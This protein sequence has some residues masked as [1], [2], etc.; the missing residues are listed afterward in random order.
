MIKRLIIVFLLA[1]FVTG[2]AMA[3]KKKDVNKFKYNSEAAVSDNGPAKTPVPIKYSPGI[4]NTATCNGISTVIPIV[5]HTQIGDTWY[6]YQQNGSMGRM[7]SVSSDG[8]RH[9]VWHY[10]SGVYGGTVY[11]YVKSNEAPAGAAPLSWIGAQ[12]VDGGAGI[13]AG[14][15]NQTHLSDGTS[16]SIYHRTAGSP[17]WYSAIAAEDSAC[18]NIW[19]RHWDIPDYIEGATSG[20]PGEWPKGEV[21]YDPTIGRDYIHIVAQEG[22]T[23][24]DVAMMIYERC[25][26]ADGPGFLDTMICQTYRGGATQTCKVVAGANGPGTFFTVSPFDS[27]CEVSPIVAVSPVDRSVAVVYMKPNDPAGSCD[28]F[29]DVLYFESDSCGDDWIDGVQWPPV[30]HN[31][32]HYGAT[33]L[34]RAYRDVAACYDYQDSLHIVWSAGVWGGPSD[35]TSLYYRAYLYHWSVKNG[36]SRIASQLQD[37]TYP[38]A[39]HLNIAKVGVSAQDPVYHPTG[40]SVYLYATWVQFD[41]AD[42]S[43]ATHGNGDLWACGSNNGG[44]YWGNVFN[45]TNTHTPNCAAGACV[46]EDWPSQAANM[47]NGNLQMEYICDKD[48]GSCIHGEGAWTDNPVYYL[49][50]A[51]EAPP[52]PPRCSLMGEIISP[53]YLWCYPPLKVTPGGSRTLIFRLTN[54]GNNTCDYSVSTDNPCIQC[55]IPPTPLYPHQ[56]ATITAVISGSGACNGTYIDGKI[57]ITTY[58]PY[59][60]TDTIEVQ[61]VVANDYYECPRDPVTYDTLENGVLRMYVNANTQEWI[62]DIGTFPDTAHEVFFNGGAFVATTE[63]N[64]TLVGRYYGYNDEH[65]LARE[66]LHLNTYSDFWLEYSWNVSIHDLNPPIDT[67]WWWFEILHE[68]VFFKPTAPDALKHCVIKFITVE[69]HDPPGW[70]PSHPAFT[71]YDDTYI[72]SFMDIDAPYDTC[73]GQYARNRAGYDATN[74]IAYQRGWDYTGVH[75]SYNDYYAG[76]ALIAGRQ[77]GEST[78]P[79]GTY[80]VRNDIHLYPQSPWGWKDGDFYRLAKDNVIGVIEQPDS[81]VDRSQIVTAR[82]IPA[83]NDPKARVSFT[84]VEVLAPGGLAQLQSY[85]GAARAWVAGKPIILC[86]D[87][88]CSGIEEV[89]DLICKINYLFKGIPAPACG[90]LARLDCNSSGVIDIGDIVAEIN[91]LYKGYPAPSIKCPGVW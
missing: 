67:K 75:P 60:P 39:H 24:G 26:I 10:T 15:A 64:D 19:N 88:N 87:C 27:S 90:P 47:Y 34:E 12:N 55:D 59:H 85:V 86:G 6:D 18:D 31:I 56:T 83:G 38:V 62:H 82:H 48:P 40:D 8:C 30:K 74:K 65:A 73:Y 72:G 32:T 66:Y 53:P 51:V 41:S 21:Q 13:N 71:G 5:E 84:M 78:T 44:Y 69:R 42:V 17:I 57:V 35:P 4:I 2:G 50:L 91:Y 79:Y 28:Y 20:I 3:A 23:S 1:A 36:K 45:L 16:I 58:D 68:N 49:E 46:S 7:I 14:Y 9:T 61:A 54:I 70:W 80:N 25:Y 63:S 22:I 52:P 76:M 11:R 29:M 33:D 43:A 89:G 81:I 77:A 37:Y